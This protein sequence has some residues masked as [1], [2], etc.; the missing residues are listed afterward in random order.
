[1][2]FDSVSASAAT[3]GTS[4]NGSAGTTPGIFRLDILR[5]APIVGV[6]ARRFPTR[7]RPPPSVA[8]ERSRSL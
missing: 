3:P 7:I 4:N 1:M 8:R 2:T 5:H 6:A